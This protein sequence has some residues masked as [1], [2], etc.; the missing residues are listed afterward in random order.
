MIM[1][2]YNLTTVHTVTNQQ[3]LPFKFFLFILVTENIDRLRECKSIETKTYYCN[4]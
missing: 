2:A 1:M 4:L 3:F